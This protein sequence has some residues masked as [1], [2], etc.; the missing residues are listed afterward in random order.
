MDVGAL[1]PIFWGFEEREKLMEFYER[2]SGARLHAA[3]FRPGGV[4]QDLPNIL[5]EDILDWTENF[6]EKLD[7]LEGLL[8]ENRIFKQRNVDIG[9][10]SKNAAIELGFSG[11]MLRG[12]GVPWD[13][14]RSQPYETYS[15]YKFSIPIGKNGDCYDRYL[16]RIQ[17]M[18][19]SLKIIKQA[20]KKLEYT[21]GDD[22]LVRGKFT[23]PKRD[24]MKNSMEALIHHFKLYTEGFRV[25][26]GSVYS[27]VEAPKGEF[28]VF[29][30]SDG[31]NKPYR[32]K[33]RAP[34]FVHLSAME[35][36]TKGHQLA[37]VSA[38][39]G[40]LDIVFGEIDR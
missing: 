30:V 26:A 18:K 34:G 38:I 31:T 32:V 17:E 16:L 4:H 8:T 20:L 35:R 29:I 27:C 11:V 7:D 6:P 9:V 14:R 23:P 2:A 37:D 12:S 39:L 36:I 40:S 33:L 15:E 19:E 28:G 13:L 24:D 5:L 10:V 22:V 21:V 3:Y 1:T 25:P